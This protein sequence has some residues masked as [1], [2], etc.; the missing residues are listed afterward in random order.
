MLQLIAL[1]GHH[2]TV[3]TTEYNCFQVFLHL[4]KCIKSGQSLLF[5]TFL[6]T[7]VSDFV[8]HSKSI[9]SYMLIEKHDQRPAIPVNC[10][11]NESFNPTG[12]L[13]TEHLRQN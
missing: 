3:R 6:S 13:L 9:T 12:I 5:D 11:E 1:T 2:T 8:A 4:N 10:S 7:S